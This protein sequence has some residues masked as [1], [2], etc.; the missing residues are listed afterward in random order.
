MIGALFPLAKPLLHSLDAEAAHNLTIRGLSLLPPRRPPPDDPRL[1]VE[2]LGRSFPNPVGL[3]A[4]Y[5]K[6]AQVPDALLGLGFGFVEVG[7]VVPKAQAGNPTPRVFRL[8]AD[9]AVINRFGLNSEGLDTVRRR[10]AARRDKPGRIG[11]NIGANKEATDRLADYVACTRALAPLV[12]FVTVNVSSPNTPG[13]RDLQGE[14]FLDDLLARVVEARDA[15]HP[16]TAILLKIAPDITLAALDAMTATALKRGVQALVVSNTTIARPATLAETALARETGGLS[17]RP[18]FKPATRLLA[19]TYLRVG[20][21]IPLVGVGGI[22]S[23]EAAWT[24]ILAG[25]SLLQL[26]SALVYQGPALIGSIKAGLV[27][28]MAAE[29]AGSL[30]GFVGRDAEA[31]AA[32]PG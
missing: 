2:I 17:G 14:A 15:V 24:K 25:A 11:V 9:G 13:L 6:G 31:L 4:G 32:L 10:L 12:D 27:A 5:D 20:G 22:D 1:A 29:G 18:L 19:Q 26:Y 3:A 21:R 16:G 8:K 23:A 30:A 28:R 7:G